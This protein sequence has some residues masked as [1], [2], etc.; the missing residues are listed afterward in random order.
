MKY[1]QVLEREGKVCKI[2][3]VGWVCDSGLTNVSCEERS[4]DSIKAHLRDPRQADYGK[5]DCDCGLG[6]E[7]AM[8]FLHDFV[9]IHTCIYDSESSNNTI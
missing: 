6:R 4:S 3:S 5:Y 7:E 2:T 9:P 8:L 1:K